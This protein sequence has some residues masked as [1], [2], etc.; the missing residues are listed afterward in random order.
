MYGLEK[1]FLNQAFEIFSSI[2]F[3]VTW[4]IVSVICCCVATANLVAS[5][6][7]IYYFSWFCG[8]AVLNWGLLLFYVEHFVYQHFLSWSRRTVQKSVFLKHFFK[9]GNTLK[10]ISMML[11]PLL[12]LSKW[13]FVVVVVFVFYIVKTFSFP[14]CKVAGM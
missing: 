7:M 4:G 14:K 13:Y 11:D 3:W 6:T 9:W 10:V 8:L 5:K 12:K 2:T 1:V